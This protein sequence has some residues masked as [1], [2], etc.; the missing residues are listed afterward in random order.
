MAHIF[1]FLLLV[2]VLANA[3]IAPDRK[4]FAQQ[5]RSIES[6]PASHFKLA[7]PHLEIKPWATSP[8]IYSPV[9]MDTDHQGRL[10]VTE[11][12][13]YMVKPRIA[14]GQSIIILEDTDNDGAADSSKVF[15]T[16]KNL[17]H[18]PLGIAIF[19]NQ[20]VLSAT[21]SIII[22]TDVDR[23]DHF[24][25]K[26]DKREVFL[27]GFKNPRHDHSVHAVIGA[28]SG[29][30]H[31]SFGNCGADLKT[32]DN[33]HFISASYYG[34]PD[35][36]G[37]KSSDGH[38]YPGGMTMRVNPDGTD[39]TP[40]GYNM[41]NPHDMIVTAY[42]DIIQ[43]D[44]D[45]PAHCRSTWIMEHANMGYSD[46]R[47]GS[48]S[49]EE[50]AKTW[51]EPPGAKLEP[52]F[53]RSHWRENYPGSHP[54]GSIYGAG[55]PTGNVYFEDN[56][57]GLK[58]TYLVADMVRKEILAC[59]PK[60]SKSA[61]DL[62]THKPFLQLKPSH[63]NEHFLPSD[64]LITPDGSLF[65]SDFHNETSRRTVQ[66][67][68]TIYR[69]THKKQPTPITP[70]IDYT[71]TNGQLAALQNPATNIRS[72]AAHLL[73]KSG[74]IVALR[75]TLESLQNN[76]DN[77]LT[78]RLLWVL[79]QLGPEGQQRTLPYLT[80]KDPNIQITAYRALRQVDPAGNNSRSQQIIKNAPISL[81][82]EIALSLRNQPFN[83]VRDILQSLLSSYDGHDRHYL[84]AL[85]IAA[86][87][88]EQKI[89]NQLVLPKFPNPKNW[90]RIPKNLAWRLHTSEAVNHLY[91]TI[92]HQTPTLDDFRH[93]LMAFASYRDEQQRLENLNH[94]QN[95]SKLPSF[96]SEP[97]QI[98]IQEIIAKDLNNLQSK[99]LTQSFQIPQTFGTPTKTSNAK[100]IAKLTGNSN[101]GKLQATKCLMCHKI[102]G[103]GVH[104]GPDLTHWGQNRTIQ[105]ISHHILNPND[106]LAHGYE[107]TTRLKTKQGH[108]AEGLM[109]NYSFH[110]GTLKL[111][112]MGGQILKVPFRKTRT[113]IE[114][115]KHSWMPSAS[116]MALT[117]QNVRD[118][119]EYLHTLKPGQRIVTKTTNKPT[120][121]D[122]KGPGWISLQ[123]EDFLN[124]NCHQ[125]TWTWRGSHAFC[126]GKPV[127]VIQ[128]HKPL[129][130]FEF[131]CE[132][133]HEKPG[134]NSGIFVWATP[135]SIADLKKGKGR[136]PHGIEVQ[137]LDLEF[138]KIY[139]QKTGKPA[140][141]FTSHGDVFPVGPVKMTPFPP[142]APN[143]KRSFP[144]K[145]TTKGINQW[146]HYFIRANNGEVRLWV[147][148]EE[149]SGGN[150]ISPSNGF[151]CL[152]SEGAPIE[153]KNLRL[154]IL[155]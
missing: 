51:E 39:L 77:T 133:K 144:S 57:L 122:T 7:H 4:T 152:E 20:I 68:G 73:I 74:P 9:A 119:A 59:Q 148:G 25:P 99:A 117:D 71:T 50:V 83:E 89:Y 60:P 98:T 84:E 42:G 110:A 62:G 8:L 140:D 85:G 82:R 29:Q 65:V 72:H 143:G 61:I 66:V 132:W 30:W 155:P 138:G 147:N 46:L 36:I 13:D 19:D 141:W 101:Q 90:T 153:F 113:Q 151:L 102:D 2:T 93:L 96:S 109:S 40:T 31:F 123:P 41:R 17:R 54:P 108:I 121:Y 124:V 49:W 10:W 150:N 11:G 23:N 88:K 114:K 118:I 97:F 81:K 16:E 53:S 100:T 5:K 79:A 142:I 52:R 1:T 67:S 56:N 131:T 64:L 104:F 145:K 106:H 125:N 26:I 95:L 32:K 45:D 154:K 146:N 126:T 86:T 137:V 55:S 3:K 24:D 33:K 37:K 43:S 70:P 139:T 92:I 130:N 35:A 105:E 12:I 18:A 22:Y 21:P 28:P 120:P 75:P 116:Q 127:G 134:G 27:T 15:V 47:D 58:G 44:N 38:I 111:K 128:Y 149:V 6:I 34:F 69:I 91:E 14:A 135:R 115:L 112:V 103:T 129:T 80:H 78:A 48:R 136:L 87:G 107:K 76:K 94:L 63:Q